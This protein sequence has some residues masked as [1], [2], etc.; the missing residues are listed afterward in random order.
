MLFR[1]VAAAIVGCLAAVIPAAAA[2]ITVMCPPPMRSLMVDLVGRFEQASG[3]KVT[4][5]LAPSKDIVTRLAGGDRTDIALLTAE[6]S[7][8]LIRAG[9]L[10]R[11]VDVV[12]SVIGVGVRA[13]SPRPDV[14][15]AD[16]FRR[17]LLAAKSFARNEGADS[18]V[19]MKGLI[20]R[21]GIAE[22]M[23]PKTT[24]VMSGYVAA[25][26][27]KGEVDLAAQQVSELMSVPGVDVTPLGADIQHVIVF[28]AVIA[29]QPAAPEAVAA[30]VKFLTS[31]AAAPVIKAKGLEP[32]RGE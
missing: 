14:G 28:S 3:H 5:V 2:E 21:L 17:T 6:A 8:G 11:R 7:D 16:A 26:V 9:K 32:A 22:Q 13:G 1:S 25:L 27:A 19:Y 29:A 31:P 15:S 23:A 20:E 10:A 4:L 24:L 18:G 30:L 12:R